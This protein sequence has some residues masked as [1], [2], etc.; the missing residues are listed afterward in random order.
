MK[1][2]RLINIEYNTWNG[3]CIELISIDDYSLIGLHFGFKYYFNI[4]LFFKTFKIY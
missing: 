4:D 1:Q 3:V 2:I